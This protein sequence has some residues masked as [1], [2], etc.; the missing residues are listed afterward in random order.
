MSRLE[1]ISLLVPFAP[2]LSGAA[3]LPSRL[4]GAGLCQRGAQ[5][6]RRYHLDRKSCPPGPSPYGPQ[7]CNCL[8][9]PHASLTAPRPF[10]KRGNEAALCGQGGRQRRREHHPTHWP[11]GSTCALLGRQEGS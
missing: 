6:G 2:R 4:Q 7:P 10:R 1:P 5:K 8:A 9:L 3:G 11:V